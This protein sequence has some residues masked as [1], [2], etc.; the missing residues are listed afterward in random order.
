MHFKVE[1]KLNLWCLSWWEFFYFNINVF[2]M[3]QT[4]LTWA[5]PYLSV[6]LYIVGFRCKVPG[7]MDGDEPRSFVTLYEL[8]GLVYMHNLQLLCCLS[9]K[10]IINYM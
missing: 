3:L 4:I 10:V 5:L 2:K 7:V 8:E 6:M 9:I 1:S